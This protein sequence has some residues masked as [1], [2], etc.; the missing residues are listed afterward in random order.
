M[1]ESSSNFSGD[2]FQQAMLKTALETIPLLSEDNYGIWRDKMNG[3]LQLRGV[4]TTLESSSDQLSS[5]END[6]IQLLL[7]SKVDLVTHNNIVTAT[8]VNSAKAIWQ[9]IK[10]RYSSSEA[11]ICAQIFNDFLHVSFKEE[12]ITHFVTKIKTSI[13]KMNDI[14]I[15]L[16]QDIL[17]YLILF[18][19]PVTLHDLKRQLMHSNKTIGVDFVCNHLI[20]YNNKVKAESSDKIIS[21]P[22]T[23]LVSGKN[24][25][26]SQSNSRCVEGYHNPKQDKNHL[27]SECFHLHPE[28]APEWWRDNQAKWREKQK[29]KSESAHYHAFVTDWIESKVTLSQN[30]LMD[31]GASA[32]F[33]NN[34]RFFSELIKSN[35]EEHISMGKDRTNLPIK[36]T[37]T[38]KLIWKHQTIALSNCLFVPDLVVNLISPG[39]LIAKG[40]SLKS[41]KGQFRLIRN[42]Q[43]LLEGKIIKNLFVVNKPKSIGQNN[44]YLSTSKNSAIST[45]DLHLSLGHASIGRLREIP[46]LKLNNEDFFCK[47]CALGKITKSPFKIQATLATKPFERLHLNLV[48]TIKPDSH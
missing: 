10:E 13:E 33:F 9:E 16:P 47:D 12:D 45:W 23:A 44:C 35:N 27:E 11:S 37:G 22:K 30:I 24:R 5:L 34:K 6:E 1:A 26:K 14:G 7:I 41:S 36:G 39:K 43:C 40:C 15:D 3:L 46:Y 19:F 32:H 18:K 4:L 28:K 25:F 38:V 20:Q 21:A 42:N 29:S 31:S 2:G 17:A 48:G 8:N